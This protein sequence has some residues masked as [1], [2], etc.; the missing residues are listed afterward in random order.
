MTIVYFRKPL[1][2]TA[3]L[4]L[5]SSGAE[6]Q[7]LELRSQASSTPRGVIIFGVFTGAEG[8]GLLGFFIPSFS[9]D[10]LPE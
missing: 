10:P 4:Q 6:D 1:K 3:S 5:A 2:R 9:S 8:F 7:G